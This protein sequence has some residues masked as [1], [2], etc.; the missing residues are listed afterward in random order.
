VLS[1]TDGVSG[2][3]FSMIFERSA[4]HSTAGGTPTPRGPRPDAV[5]SAE[6]FGI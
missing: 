4:L 6:I 5:F 2:E 1:G 3:I